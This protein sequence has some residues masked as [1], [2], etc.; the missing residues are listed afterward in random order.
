MEKI[1]SNKIVKIKVNSNVYKI[2][3]NYNDNVDDQQF[4]IEYDKL[5]EIY[6]YGRNFML[7]SLEYQQVE[8]PIQF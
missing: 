7:N 8:E 4:I 6:N 2:D 3:I 5:P 1:S